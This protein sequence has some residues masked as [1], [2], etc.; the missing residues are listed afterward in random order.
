MAM[1]TETEVADGAVTMGCEEFLDLLRS[2]EIA[3]EINTYVCGY[4]MV[5]LG[6]YQG[7]Q[8]V[9]RVRTFTAA[10]QW[11]ADACQD[12]LPAASIRIEARPRGEV[13][14]GGHK[15][16]DVVQEKSSPLGNTAA[17]APA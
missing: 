15:A 9:Q 14:L 1:H 13:L 16:A 4:F 17:P 5:S 11:L 10:V 2:K 6:H 12:R 3:F 8:K 7:E